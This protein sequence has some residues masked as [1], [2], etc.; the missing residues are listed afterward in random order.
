[1]YTVAFNSLTMSVSWIEELLRYIYSMFKEYTESK[2]NQKKAWSV[3]TRLARALL[4]TIDKPP[5]GIVRSLRTK[6]PRLMKQAIFYS[7]IKS[8]DEMQKLAQGGLKNSPVVANELFKFLARNTN[9]EAIDKLQQQV[10]TL[11]SENQK[12][13]NDMNELKS[14]V[15]EA[16]KACNTCNNNYD[17]QKSHI[18]SLE[19]RVQKL[20]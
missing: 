9:V 16:I 3:T 12:L 1:M 5:S 7:T 18:G 19:K 4:T 15:A 2:F 8:L 17:K 10:P 11:S 14:K 13:R 6:K 20:E